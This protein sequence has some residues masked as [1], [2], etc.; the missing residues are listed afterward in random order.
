MESSKH[1]DNLIKRKLDDVSVEPSKLNFTK[2]EANLKKA[3]E[4][5]SKKWLMIWLF[6]ILI[7]GSVFTSYFLMNSDSFQTKNQLAINNSSEN[8]TSVNQLPESNSNNSSVENTSSS[9]SNQTSSVPELRSA[10]TS[11]E[12]FKSKPTTT[13]SSNEPV[14]KDR[15]S[16]RL[17]SSH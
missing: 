4:S 2:L 7:I 6:S 16:T 12:D 9:N 15:K 10:S 13:S 5:S 3:Q 8:K 11:H 1:N 17:N 14:S